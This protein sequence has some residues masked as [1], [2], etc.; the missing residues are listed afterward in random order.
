MTI[1]RMDYPA[2]PG[3]GTS[4]HLHLLTH[5]KRLGRQGNNPLII[6][7]GLDRIKNGLR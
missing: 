1:Q 2:Q 7:K 4:L 6:D 3:K 5:A